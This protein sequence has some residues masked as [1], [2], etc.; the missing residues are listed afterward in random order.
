MAGEVKAKTEIVRQHQDLVYNLGLKLTNQPDA[1][2]CVLQET[3]L[4]VF[5]K[6]GSFRLESSLRTWIYRIAANA[7]MM[8]LRQRKGKADSLDEEFAE[9]ESSRHARM[10]KSLDRDP[11]ELL[12]DAEFKQALAAAMADL[13]DSWRVPFVL[14]D[15][16]GLS[17][18]E[19]ADTLHTS[20]P[21]VKA[22]LHRARTRLRDHLTDFIEK[23]KNIP[24]I[25]PEKKEPGRQP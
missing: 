4:K 13:P 14:K 3:F 16:E 5:E 1:A 17:L 21:A 10:L 2:E 20:V 23:H 7:A 25:T 11:L 22:A 6:L 18:Q 12:M 8:H 15:I 19:V 24:R 9:A